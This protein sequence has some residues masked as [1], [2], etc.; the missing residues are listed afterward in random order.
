MAAEK[1][2][3]GAGKALANEMKTAGKLNF[4]DA[5]PVGAM[6]ART[7]AV[8][9]KMEEAGRKCDSNATERLGFL[10]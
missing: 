1:D 5:D 8:R 7:D 4:K 2:C 10:K 3:Y 6:Q 9:E